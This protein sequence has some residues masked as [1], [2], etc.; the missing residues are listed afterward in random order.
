MFQ[1][2]TDVANHMVGRW[3]LTRTRYNLASFPSDLDFEGQ[4][5]FQEAR[6][7]Y[8]LTMSNRTGEVL[9]ASISSLVIFGY[10]GFFYIA[11]P[12]TRP[13]HALSHCSVSCV[14]GYC[15]WKCERAENNSNRIDG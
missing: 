6:T 5:S 9:D 3:S 15:L 12:F 11:L 1:D 7:N 10:V 13:S 14:S 8:R 4:A 2:M